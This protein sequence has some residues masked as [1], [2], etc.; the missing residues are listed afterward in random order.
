MK[1]QVVNAASAMLDLAHFPT[2][3]NWPTVA[4]LAILAL[5]SIAGYAMNCGYTLHLQ[6]AFGDYSGEFDLA[7]QHIGDEEPDY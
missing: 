2:I 6:G 7:P 3:S 5:V 1:N 4:G